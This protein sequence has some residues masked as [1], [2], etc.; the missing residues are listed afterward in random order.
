MRLKNEEVIQDHFE[1][2]EL[3]LKEF[4]SVL[5]TLTYDSDRLSGQ[6]GQREVGSLSGERSR[7]EV[8]VWGH[9]HGGHN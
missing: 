2:F 9:P 8:K 5:V 4:N 1:S 6:R 3:W 7:P